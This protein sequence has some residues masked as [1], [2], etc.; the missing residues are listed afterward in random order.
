M[1]TKWTDNQL[2]AINAR[3]G[4]VLVSAAAGSGK[5]AVLVERVLQM[6]TDSVNPVSID[7]LLIVTYTR[8]AAAQ[9]KERISAKL[10]ELIMAYPD[11]RFYRRQL[12]MLPRA[13]ISTVDS[14]CSDICREFFHELNIKRD[15]KIA[16]QGQ[17]SVLS[18]SALEETL[19]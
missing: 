4:D 1:S 10:S 16:E 17:L 6:L 2:L 19:N 12:L 18:A 14:F 8:A 3:G 7:R 15:Y 5:T 9:L 13:H 11:N